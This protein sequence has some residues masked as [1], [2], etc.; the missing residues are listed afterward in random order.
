M[1]KCQFGD[2]PDTLVVQSQQKNYINDTAGSQK[3]IATDKEL[4]MPFQAKTFG[5]CKLQPTGTSFKPCMPSIT[6]WDGF[7]EKT[8]LQANQGYPLLEDSKATCAIAGAP[9]VEITFHGQ[10]ATPSAQNIENADEE[11]LSQVI[12]MVNVK[13][14]D[15]PSPYDA[16]TVTVDEEEADTENTDEKVK[17][18]AVFSTCSDYMDLTR[19]ERRGT[20]EPDTAKLYG[21]DWMRDDYKDNYGYY[22][23]S[24]RFKKD[25]DGNRTNEA[26]CDK[27]PNMKFSKLEGE[28]EQIDNTY[29]PKEKYYTPWLSLLPDTSARVDLKLN[30]RSRPDEIKLVYDD[31]FI[32][33]SHEKINGKIIQSGTKKLSDLLITCDSPYADQLAVEIHADDVVVGKLNMVPNTTHRPINIGWCFVETQI[34]K[35][36][37]EEKLDKIVDQEKLNKMLSHL[38]LRQALFKV[39]VAP[40]FE[41]LNLPQSYPLNQY[42]VKA[43]VCPNIQQADSDIIAGKVSIDGE[44]TSKSKRPTTLVNGGHEIRHNKIKIDPATVFS[45]NITQY[46]T[47]K[48]WAYSGNKGGKNSIIEK[49]EFK[50][51]LFKA[52]RDDIGEHNGYDIVLVFVNKK[53]VTHKKDSSNKKIIERGVVS[54]EAEAFNSKFV[55]LYE[56]FEEMVMVHEVLHA[57]TLRHSFGSPREHSFKAYKT[58]NIMDYTLGG[59]TDNRE[60]LWKWQWE[61]LWEWYTNK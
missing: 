19:Q 10:T 13:E 32:T 58:K 11:L 36:R 4:G 35:T 55:V 41:T 12:P 18:V 7:F 17:C 24:K 48:G 43:K 38:G 57:M 59:A 33:V 37:D 46:T 60:S 22:W 6:G 34:G 45:L 54:G 31:A 20:L 9:C 49:G 47:P 40:S 2:V 27:I 15:M 53:A 51:A 26:L 5:Q 8:Q 39:N 3:L 52:Y 30:W 23:D 61:K 21:F 42:L 1:C 29:K 56:G 44:I 14:I 16:I 25:S 50:K 28:Y